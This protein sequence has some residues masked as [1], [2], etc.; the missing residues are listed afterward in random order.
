MI[1][2]KGSRGEMVKLI[3][4]ALNLYADG[5]FG[6]LTEERVKEFQ[7]DNGLKP[8]GIVGP[9][10]MLKIPFLST[11]LKKSTR[12]IDE[13]IVHCTATPEGKNYT[14]EDI[15]ACHIKQGWSDIG[16]HYL[17]DLN[18][19]CFPGRDV[20]IIGAHC[21]GHN[22]HSIGVA[23]VGGVEKD[24]VKK[25]KDT[26]TLK[27]K[28]ALLKLLTELKT[29]YPKAKIVGHCDYAAKDCPSFDAKSEYVNI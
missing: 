2:K 3:Q 4:Q 23:Y 27:Q 1:Y 15:R 28:A 6:R 20:N 22:S 7:R 16:Y 12:R 26:R 10:T 17:I 9:A 11:K 13:I 29:L 25:K 24:N 14:V 18:G 21:E 5:I 19:H 8:D